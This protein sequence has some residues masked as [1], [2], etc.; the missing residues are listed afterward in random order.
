V[1]ASVAPSAEL[2]FTTVFAYQR[3]AA[4]RTAIELD[5]FTAVGDG[6]STVPAIAR[7][8]A[9]S[10]RGVRILCNYL[11]IL[12]FLTK[13]GDEYQLTPDS[14]VFLTKRSPA[15][16]GGTLQFLTNPELMK[17]AGVLTD[18][19]R[20]GKVPA[21]GNDTVQ[22]ENPIW[23][24]FARAMVPM[25]MPAAQAMA[26]VLDVASAGPIKVLDVAAGHG[27]YGITI[28]QRNPR[29]EVVAVDWK[30]VLA[31]AQEHAEGA[32]VAARY[33]LC[34]GSAF[35]VDWGSG[36][37]IALVTNF[38]HHFDVETCTAL[39][40]RIGKSLNPGGR[41]AVLEFVCNDDHVTPPMQASFAMNMLSGT[42]NGDAYSYSQIVGMLRD[43]GFGEFTRH[44][45][46]IPQ[47]VVVGTR[48]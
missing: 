33:R 48:T 31:V 2:F 8:C 24:D 3:T 21:A 39:L 42:S 18:T 28:A 38:L 20:Q 16:L 30:S 40:G 27:Y 26:E 10:E 36:Y 32:G 22:D 12:G 6:A 29:A 25:M 5:L 34:P 17:N 45:M 14:S 13:E 35:T 44:E 43:A 9:A 15:Y 7:S 41:V 37:D 47:S 23:Q 19:V 11:T 46:P 1:P 4:L